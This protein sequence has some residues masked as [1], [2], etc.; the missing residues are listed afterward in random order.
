MRA[1]Q[2]VSAMDSAG[3]DTLTKTVPGGTRRRAVRLLT[4]VPFAGVLAA[5]LLPFAAFSAVRLGTDAGETL[6]GTELVNLGESVV[7]NVVGTRRVI[8]VGPLL[9]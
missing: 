9:V 6:T 4:I 3:F 7:E 2:E 1:V 5:L 8:G